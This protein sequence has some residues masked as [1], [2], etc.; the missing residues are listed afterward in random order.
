VDGDRGDLEDTVL[1]VVRR[2]V[3]APTDLDEDTLVAS[4]GSGVGERSRREQSR[5]E[6]PPPALVE[7]VEPVEPVVAV[8]SGAVGR[9]PV[10]APAPLT[11]AFR[12]GTHDPIPLEVPALI[13]RRP[14]RPR[15]GGAEVPRLVRVPSP[16]SEISATHLEVRQEGTAV[17]VTDLG[18]TNGTLVLS[19]AIAPRKLRQGESLVVAVGAVV[20]IGDGIRIEILPASEAAQ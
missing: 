13:G 11:H 5:P 8:A 18:S 15:I 6:Q 20:D 17:I 1:G 19:A 14:S 9:V 4:S 12:I 10:A 2:P 16:A 7:P 3:E